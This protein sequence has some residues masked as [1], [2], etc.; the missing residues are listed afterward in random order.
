MYVQNNAI[1]ALL[2]D[3]ATNGTAPAA[4]SDV[5]A[6]GS[7]SG[8]TIA[9]VPVAVVGNA[10][11]VFGDA[12]ATDTA[13]AADAAGRSD[14]S[15]VKAPV[16]VCGTAAA[17]LGDAA[18]ACADQPDASGAS[19]VSAPVTVCGTSAAVAGDSTSACADQPDA[20]GASLISAP[21]TVC[22]T[23]L[24][25]FGQS[26]FACP[27]FASGVAAP[28]A[29]VDVVPAALPGAVG[30]E[31]APA[32]VQEQPT[33]PRSDTGIVQPESANDDVAGLAYTGMDLTGTLAAGALM[34]V[35]G[36]G[37]AVG[38]HRRGNRIAALA[39]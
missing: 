25:V 30:N 8:S 36:A 24:A 33:T 15:V 38:A 16:T 17:V 23:S 11:T 29:P 27:T 18:S 34:V 2:S 4:E 32:G 22:G 5:D 31:A 13:G 10:V 37:G 35:L 28:R 19:L 1:S 7:A 6:S 3:A 12:G 9:T 26:H 20:S 39:G 14:A 21:V